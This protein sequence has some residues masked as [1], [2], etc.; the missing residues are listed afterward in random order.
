M[1][2]VPSRDGG[3][4]TIPNCRRHRQL[5]FHSAL[6]ISRCGSRA[7]WPRPLRAQGTTTTHSFTVR[8]EVHR[9]TGA[10]GS[11][12]EGVSVLAG[13]QPHRYRLYRAY[14]FSAGPVR[15]DRWNVDRPDGRRRSQGNGDRDEH[16]HRFVPASHD[17]RHRLLLH[18][19]P[20]GREL[21]PGGDRH[22]VQGVH[23]TGVSVRINSVTR[24]D[25]V[26]QIGG[27]AEQVSVAATSAVLQTATTDV[28][29]NLDTR[30][31]E[32]LPL[33]GYRNYQ[34]LINL[35]PGATPAHFQNAV[36]DTPGRALTTNVNGQ[37]RGANNTRVD[38][39]ADI[40]V[41]M[42]HHAV[43]VPPVESIQEVNISTNDFDAEQGMTGGAAVTV[44][45]KSG[46]N[47]FRGTA[48][49]CTT[50]AH[51]RTFTWDENRAGGK[52][53]PK[54][55]AQHQRRQLRRSDQEEQAV[56]LRELG[57]DVRT[58]GL[59]QPAFSVP[60][61]DFRSGNFNRMLGA[62]C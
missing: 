57:R 22:R 37:D 18:S 13:P 39:S 49:R 55:Y 60:T 34:S 17:E 20:A 23:P 56:L 62:P 26:I 11:P 44:I 25:I 28:S 43:Y 50:A 3:G 4:S 10:L 52:E 35:V 47:D 2:F 36:T 12:G 45:T 7:A 31:M 59:L 8:M 16:V 51:L 15:F 48:F 21:R 38:G 40:L 54:T 53:K 19:K 9:E 46:T 61:A 33:S 32:N 29:T 5:P 27:V 24:T 58:G 6:E 1:A 14:C 41:T 30:A 42:P